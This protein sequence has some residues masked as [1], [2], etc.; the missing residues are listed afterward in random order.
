MRLRD[1]QQNEQEDQAG[2][3]AV[4][5]LAEEQVEMDVDVELEPADVSFHGLHFSKVLKFGCVAA[6][7]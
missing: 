7:T 5:H 4:Q 6:Y 1:L 2:Q 3:A